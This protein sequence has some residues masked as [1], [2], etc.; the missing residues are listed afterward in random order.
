MNIFVENVNLY[1]LKS[2]AFECFRT[3]A[4]LYINASEKW[5]KDSSYKKYFSL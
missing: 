1:F 5:R 3:N 2:A 4:Q